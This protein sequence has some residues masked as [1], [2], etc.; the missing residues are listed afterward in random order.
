MVSSSPLRSSILLRER[1]FPACRLGPQRC[2]TGSFWCKLIPIGMEGPRLR[3]RS[4]GSGAFA[5]ERATTVMTAVSG[6]QPPAHSGIGRSKQ[7]WI[8]VICAISR[9]SAAEGSFS[10]AAEKLHI[11]Q[12]PLSRQIQQLEE[13]LGVLLLD[14]GRPITMT[15]AGRYLLR[16]GAAGAATRR[17]DQRH[18]HAHRQAH[19]AAVQHWFFVASTLYDTLPEMIRDFRILVPD[20]EVQL[21]EMTT[22]EQISAFEGRSAS[23]TSASGACASIG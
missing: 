4:V 10:R 6:M 18:D 12:P 16:P 7:R 15:E 23:M 14:R 8:Y 13:E 5:R 2:W 21:L 19:G 11:A 1:F 17:R 3:S 9:P 20:V 22:L